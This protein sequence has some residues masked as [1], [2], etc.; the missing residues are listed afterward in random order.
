L[1]IKK[2]ETLIAIYPQR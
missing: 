2:S 1:K